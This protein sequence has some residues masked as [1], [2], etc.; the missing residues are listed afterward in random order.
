MEDTYLEK[1]RF[2]HFGLP[3]FSASKSKNALDNQIRIVG[4]GIR[5]VE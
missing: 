3:A 2:D 4:F 1:Y 5:R